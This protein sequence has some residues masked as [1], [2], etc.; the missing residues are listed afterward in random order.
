MKHA[1]KFNTAKFSTNQ[2][3]GTWQEEKHNERQKALEVVEKA[4]DLP[5][6]KNKPIK[7]DLK[8]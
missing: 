2:R 6:L 7:Y 1:N 3:I 4:K 5:H 8:R